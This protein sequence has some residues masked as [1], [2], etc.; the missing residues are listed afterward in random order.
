MTRRISKLPPITT[1]D[2]AQWVWEVPTPLLAGASGDIAALFKAEGVE[3]HGFLE[4]HAPSPDASLF[5]REAIQNSWDAAREWRSEC[6]KTKRR[7]APFYLEFK[8]SELT[9]F[10]KRRV[11]YELGLD[12]HAHQLAG[13]KSAKHGQT[14]V[15]LPV[16]NVL[17]DLTNADIPLRILTMSEHGGLGMPG[18][19]LGGDSRMLQALLRVG[20]TLKAQGAGGSFGYGK[21]GLIAASAIRTVIAYTAFA[22]DLKDPGVTRR[23]LGVTYWKPHKVKE[24]EYN[25]W[26]RLGEKKPWGDIM[27][28]IPFEN[29]VADKVAAS[30]GLQLR[31]PDQP[32]QTGTTFMIVDPTISPGDLRVAIER[33]WWPAMMDPSDGLKVRILDYD[34]TVIVPTVPRDDPDM[35]PFVRAFELALRPQDVIDDAEAS[36]PLGSYK[37]HD[38]PN[39][40]NLG[41]L[42]VVA[43]PQ[44][45]SFPEDEGVDHC[46]LIALVRG[47]R[48]VVNYYNFKRNLGVPHVR[49]VFL[50]DQAVDDLLRQTEDKAHTKWETAKLAGTHPHSQMIAS[51]VQLRLRDKVA[52]F[53]NRFKKPP[54]RPGDL[55]LPILDELSRLMRG[56]KPKTPDPERRQVE[57]RILTPAHAAPERD[58]SLTCRATVEVIVA[59][60]VWPEL[61]VDEVLVAVSLSIA[62]VEDERLG[63][64]LAIN[65]SCENRRFNSESPNS[66]RLTFSGP[67]RAGERVR[68]DVQSKPYASDWTVRFTPTAQITEPKVK[69]T[70]ISSEVKER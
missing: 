70:R 24:V 14:G 42:G 11:T 28:A 19:F 68:F 10:E 12:E 23:L 5:A 2:E 57:I 27:S 59:D 64:P 53:K 44:G 61:S 22:E 58:G 9:G 69:A 1:K 52:E 45:W 47:P 25:G 30:L 26:A 63:D 40:Y 54:P 36:I 65:A 49:G 46:S 39:D 3:A 16:G 66:G 38:S 51:Q 48:M 17:D 67:L 4:A 6:A 34:D 41:R 18:S 60:W 29:A 55:N 33:Y 56:R 20:Y 21:A 8:F 43:D 15:G 62:Y 35:N 13:V 37:P 32:E 7:T 50:A 31:D